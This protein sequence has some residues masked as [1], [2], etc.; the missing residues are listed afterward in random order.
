M[1]VLGNTSEGVEKCPLGCGANWHGL[2]RM[3]ADYG[4]PCPGPFGAPVPVDRLKDEYPADI[5]TRLDLLGVD[6]RE[7]GVA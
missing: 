4:T 6:E 5:W 1:S 7:A 3:G 2:P